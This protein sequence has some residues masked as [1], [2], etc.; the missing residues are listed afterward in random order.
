M[1]LNLAA[2]Q[3]AAHK[4]RPTDYLSSSAYLSAIYLDAKAKNFGFTYRNYAE[5]L[6][7]GITNYMH[8]ICTA[9]RK[10]TVKAAKDLVQAL[11]LK[12]NQR[13]YFELL[14]AHECSKTADE[15]EKIFEKII[16]IKQKSLP[17]NLERDM[18]EY[19]SEW[20]FPVV[21]ELAWLP[22]F[23][24]DPE[25]IS[26]TICPKISPDEAAD[27]LKL[28]Y[29]L[30]FL[31]IDEETGR[32][33]PKNAHV[34]TG[35]LVQSLSATRYHQVMMELARNAIH[36]VSAPE[37]DFQALTIPVSEELLGELKAD[38]EAFWRMAL[39]KSECCSEPDRVYQ[40]NIQLFPVSNKERG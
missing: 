2:I 6:G 15:K 33:R 34:T 10:L 20:Y 22:N 26:T 32:T 13:K 31:I 5:A 18:M 23:T 39:T 25:W 4:L 8:L 38:T 3:R 24:P 21:R 17:Q 27:A 28:L 40:L 16:E 14:V 35:S 12:G 36:A 7:Y 19:L 37:R 30:G 11:S 1:N 29:R 9:K